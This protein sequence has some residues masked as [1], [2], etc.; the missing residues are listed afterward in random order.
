M[1]LRNRCFNN[2]DVL[3]FTAILILWGL[4]TLRTGTC[5][6]GGNCFCRF[7][8]AA[9]CKMRRAAGL[10]QGGWTHRIGPVHVRLD[11]MSSPT[12]VT[13][14]AAFKV[15]GCRSNRAAARSPPVLHPGF[16][17]ATTHS[18]RLTRADTK[19]HA[20]WMFGIMLVSCL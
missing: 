2:F 14:V 17:L 4:K 9:F 7:L 1:F 11:H 3:A 19:V 15:M 10:R 6:G 18:A 16:E 8:P 12:E 5:P 20:A 13:D